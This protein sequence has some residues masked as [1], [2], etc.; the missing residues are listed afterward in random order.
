MRIS[1]W[2]S[3][4]C[5]SDLPA[6]KPAPFELPPVDAKYSTTPSNVD[7]SK[8]VPKVDTFPNLDFPDLQHATLA[9]GSKLI[10]AEP[11]EIPVVQMRYLFDGGYASDTDG[12]PGRPGFALKLLGAGA[13]QPG[14]P[15]F[16]APK[17]N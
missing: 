2:S 5:S 9:N 8:G 17:Q 1:D 16:S 7:R 14:P 10:L 11:H 6:A 12:K 15:A 3:D 4:V 13:G